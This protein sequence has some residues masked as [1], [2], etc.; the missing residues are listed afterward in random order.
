MVSKV[1]KF[2]VFFIHFQDDG[3]IIYVEGNI[4][5]ELVEDP[6][7]RGFGLYSRQSYIDQQNFPPI[8]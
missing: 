7:C 3:I 4:L 6:K 1:F 8:L 2:F 5:D